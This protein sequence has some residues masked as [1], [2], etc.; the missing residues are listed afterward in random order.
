MSELVAKNGTLYLDNKQFN[1]YSGTIHYFRVHHTQWYERLKKLRDCGL[2]TVETY[3]AWNV[4]S[5]SEDEF[6]IDKNSDFV[7]FIELAKEL[8]LYVIV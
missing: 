7:R 8:G 2:N 3:I 6:T 1:L 5:K 4:H